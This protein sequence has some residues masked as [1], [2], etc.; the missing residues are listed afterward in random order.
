ME[1]WVEGFSDSDPATLKPVLATTGVLNFR[2]EQSLRPDVPSEFFIQ[3]D[4]T[5]F[6]IQFLRTVQ[7]KLESCMCRC[8]TGFP[9]G[10]PGIHF[11]T[12]V[13]DR[14]YDSRCSKRLIC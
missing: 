6:C 14:R 13:G 11:C 4:I 8:C 9:A 2:Y 7:Q 12:E 10:D 1:Q 3:M 5:S